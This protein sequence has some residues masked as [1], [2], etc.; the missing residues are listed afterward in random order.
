[1]CVCKNVSSRSHSNEAHR[2][3]VQKHPDS[4]PF[5]ERMQYVYVVA[6]RQ[7]NYSN[8]R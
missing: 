6:L 2:K 5:I 4:P 8:L 3:Y 1:V 7:V